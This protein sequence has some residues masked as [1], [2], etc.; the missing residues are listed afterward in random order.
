MSF[1]SSVLWSLSPGRH[2]SW[3]A[4]PSPPPRS[5]STHLHGGGEEALS[6]SS[7]RPSCRTPPTG[8]AASAPVSLH[9]SPFPSPSPAR[10]SPAPHT[11]L[12]CPRSSLASLCHPSQ[13][14]SSHRSHPRLP[15]LVT[16]HRHRTEADAQLFPSPPDC[17]VFFFGVC[18]C[19]FFFFFAL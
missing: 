2:P 3:Q 8:S 16:T 14:I 13:I 19:F 15:C 7:S 18:V 4:P 9:L 12:M 1:L 10:P 17:V 6:S 5:H 11:S